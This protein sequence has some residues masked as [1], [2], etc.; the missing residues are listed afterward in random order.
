MLVFY[1]KNQGINSISDND[2]E[3]ITEMYYIDTREIINTVFLGEGLSEFYESFRLPLYYEKKIPKD[4]KIFNMT[5]LT[6]MSLLINEL[7]THV[8]NAYIK[9][10]LLSPNK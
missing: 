2:S 4:A 6:G 8:R 7:N 1:F 9:T 10:K 5:D 3:K